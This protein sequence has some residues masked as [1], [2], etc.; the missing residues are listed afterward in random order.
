MTARKREE[1]LQDTPISI[2]AFSGEDL[3]VRGVTNLFAIGQY[4]PNM[5]FDKAATIGGSNNAAVVYIRGIGQDAAVPTIDLG[6]GTYVDGVYLAR[7]VGGALELIDVERIEVLRGPQGTL[8]GRNTIGG[9]INITTRKP[10]EEFAADVGIT[11][12]SDQLAIV[13]A[14]VNG[15]LT[16]ELF[17]K[18][19]IMFKDRDG[20]VFRPDGTDF[21]DEHMFSGNAAFRWEPVD[22]LTVD[23]NVDYTHSTTNGAPFIIESLDANAAFPAFYNGFLVPPTEGCFVPPPVGMGSTNTPNPLCY[24]A[25][26]LPADDSTDFGTL[27]PK[28][29]LEV[30]GVSATIEYSINS[31]LTFKSITSYRDTES[32]YA[33][34]Q[35]HSPLTLFHVETDTEQDQ[36]TQELQLLGTALDDKLQWILGAYYFEE[37]ALYVE[38]I[39]FPPVDFQSGGTVDNDSVALFAQGTYDVTDRLNFTVGLRYTDDTKR[40]TPDQFIVANRNDAVPPP[41]VGFGPGQ[42]PPIPPPGFPILPPTQATAS[43]SEVNPMASIGYQFT[44]ELLTY[45][46][47]SE[48]FKSGGF[49]QRIFPPLAEAPSFLPEFVSVYELGLKWEGLGNRLRLN[50]AFFFSDYD[51]LQIVSQSMSVAPLVQNAGT[52]EISGFELDFQAVPG[53]GWLV[54]GGIGFID[55]EYTEIDPG[56]GLTLDNELVKTPEW[57][58]TATVSYTWELANGATLTPQIDT[59]Y[60]DSYFSNAINSPNTQQDAF[61]LLNFGITYQTEDGAWTV[62]VLGQNLSDER[63]ISAGFSEQNGPTSS[64]GT[65]ELIRDRGRQWRVAVKRR[66][67]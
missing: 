14:G 12:G 24:N 21:G 32:Q 66:F 38:T 30:F 10:T 43:V 27:P 61:S 5:T 17:A 62:S 59:T 55:G 64:L 28:D 31:N 18:G 48:G 50:G 23:V 11:Y 33:L 8:F 9:A 7:A 41:L 45:L 53:D 3:E 47:Y 44:D 67:D 26:W 2:K 6:V 4:T 19:A 36:F 35:D 37:E 1:S 40:F 58:A 25:Q 49:T 52:A 60:R 57:T 16:D 29:D 22:S 39:T 20:Y 63:F 15:A 42:V 54:Q 56:T 46:T 13:R 65:A 51:D 34:D